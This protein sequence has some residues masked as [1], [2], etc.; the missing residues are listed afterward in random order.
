[1]CGSELNV[2]LFSRPV[3][4]RQPLET[5]GVQMIA[6]AETVTT[7]EPSAGLMVLGAGALTALLALRKRAAG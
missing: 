3:L 6:S 7:P 5:A 1:M 4:K 2:A